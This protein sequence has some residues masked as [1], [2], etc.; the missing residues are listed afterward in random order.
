MESFRKNLSIL[1][2]TSARK[3]RFSKKKRNPECII[4]SNQIN[5]LFL[6]CETK[7][8]DDQSDH[9]YF[10]VYVK[11]KE[12]FCK[13]KIKMEEGVMGSE[14][15]QFTIMEVPNPKRKKKGKFNFL[16]YSETKIMLIT[17]KSKT[18]SVSF[19]KIVD[20]NVN[21]GS[22]IEYCPVKKLYYIPN[23]N[24]LEIWDRTFSHQV[25]VV[26]LHNNINAF[27]VGL[28]SELLIIYDKY[29]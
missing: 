10:F 11:F 26:E 2:K 18:S 14:K 20:K 9:F 15:Y 5:N 23:G 1:N 22:K 24:K 29:R 16:V 17:F 7:Q 27:R 6:F 8:D 19:S 13:A 12:T 21:P 4:A 25:Y 28:N 3:S